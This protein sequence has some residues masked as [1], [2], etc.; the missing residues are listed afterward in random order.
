V[1][2]SSTMTDGFRCPYC[3]RF[4]HWVPNRWLGG[5]GSFECRNCG[6]F[7]DF[8]RSVLFDPGPGSVNGSRG[9]PAP[10]LRPKPVRLP[11]I[12]V[13]DDLPEQCDLYSF[14]LAPVARVTTATDGQR[15]LELAHAQHP[16]L[17]LLD[18]VMPGLSGWD[19]CERMRADAET[20]DIPVVFLTGLDQVDVPARARAVGAQAVLM[21][22]CP[23]ERLLLTIE[24]VMA[25]GA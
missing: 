21:K 19:V 25:A 22:P 7:P 15:G 4:L 14:L 3:G 11:R 9:E 17:V 2:A 8:R 13:V 12:L 24:N 16:D 6:D 23:V 10:L 20:A 5:S 1:K 18:V